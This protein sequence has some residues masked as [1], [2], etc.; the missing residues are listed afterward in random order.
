MV[1][2]SARSRKRATPWCAGPALRSISS[3]D[4]NASGRAWFEVDAIFRD[5]RG[6]AVVGSSRTAGGREPTAQPGEPGQ[7]G[8]RMNDVRIAREFDACLPR[9]GK[10]VRISSF[11]DAQVFVRRWAIRDKD[12]AIRALLRKMERANSAMAANGAIGELKRE[13]AARGLLPT[14]EADKPRGG[15]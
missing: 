5:S 15:L 10:P 4:D 1:W 14:A 3:A 2:C 12:R 11:H 7:T 13:L 9:L 8:C 6:A